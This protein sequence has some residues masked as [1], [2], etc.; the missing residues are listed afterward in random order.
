MVIKVIVGGGMN[1]KNLSFGELETV[2]RRMTVSLGIIASLSRLYDPSSHEQHFRP[3]HH[4]LSLSYSKITQHASCRCKVSLCLL[5]YLS[6]GNFKSKEV[7][8]ALRKHLSICH[9]L[10][11]FI[12][13]DLHVTSFLLIPIF[14]L[15][16]LLTPLLLP[17][18]LQLRLNIPPSLLP[19]GWRSFECRIPFEIET[20][21]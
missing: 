18:S 1:H 8:S 2:C 20:H 10:V 12:I 9:I 13:N 15:L 4:H 11:P 19:N 21:E 7:G 17:Q 5:T 16:L 14:V 3:P 6:T